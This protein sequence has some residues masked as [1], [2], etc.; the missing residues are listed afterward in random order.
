MTAWQFA[1]ERPL[2]TFCIV[3]MVTSCIF[4]CWNRLMRC[5][6]LRK[7]GWPPSHCD[8]DGDFPPAPDKDDDDDKTEKRPR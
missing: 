8:A 5:I 3:W 7:L 2:L 6:N 1:N 4:R